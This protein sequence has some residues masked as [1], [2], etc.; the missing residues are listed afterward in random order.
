MNIRALT[1]GLKVLQ[2]LNRCGAARAAEIARALDIP[3]PT[4]YR[5]LHTLEEE[6]YIQFSSSDAR[7]RVSPLAAALGDNAAARSKLCQAAAPTL[8]R[9]TAQYTWPVDLSAYEDGHMV[10]QESTHARSQLSVDPGMIGFALPML[11]S[12]AGRAYLACCPDSEREIILDMLRAEN[13]PE[14]RT[15]LD[16]DWLEKHLGLFRQ[17]GYASRDHRT[18]RPKTSS[19]AVPIRHNDQVTGCLSIIWIS[20]ALTMPEA[21]EQ[22]RDILLFSAAEIADQL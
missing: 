14:D 9:L 13:L 19:I 11:R 3:R 22:Y 21:V 20:K 16:G 18:F 6:G 8:S 12:S 7:A 4:V 10:I 1:R 15:F 5:L 17:Q 2:Y